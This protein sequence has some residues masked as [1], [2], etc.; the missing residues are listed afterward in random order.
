MN[1]KQGFTL[2][3]LLVVMAIIG[4]LAAILLPALA[5]ARE[6]ARRSSCANNLKQM[7]LA[8]KMYSNEGG[9][10]FPHMK[11]MDCTGTAIAWDQIFDGASVYP[12]YLTD[13]N[14]LICPSNS[15]GATALETYDQGKTLYEKW[16]DIPGFSKDGVV[17]PCELHADPY[18]YYGWAF[19]NTMFATQ[20]DLD[21]FEHEVTRQA[22]EMAADP[23]LVNQDL[24]L[25]NPV[26]GK[27][28]IPRL[29]EGIER[30]FIT[31]INN[32]AAS[33]L[34]QSDIVILHDAVSDEPAHFNHLPGG[35]NILY[36]DGHVEFQLWNRGSGPFPLNKAGLILHEGSML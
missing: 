30:F 19:I 17:E 9:G 29:K 25:E 32:A 27:T 7:A 13:L 14:V 33:A 16:A 35:A 12:E 18:H 2:I 10:L 8:F 11:V 34:A 6:A 20:T 15:A 1:R 4:I 23:N 22:A 3:E 26:G 36:M 5:R 24:Q 21:N 28:S 31:D